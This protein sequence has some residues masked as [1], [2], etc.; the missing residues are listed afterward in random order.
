MKITPSL[1]DIA[2]K[3]LSNSNFER[4][5]TDENGVLADN[6]KDNEIAK[7]LQRILDISK[8]I[9]DDKELY[10]RLLEKDENAKIFAQEIRLNSTELKEFKDFAKNIMMK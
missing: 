10:P 1:K 5:K 9:L 3:I 7:Y 2:H 4:L 8:G 6:I